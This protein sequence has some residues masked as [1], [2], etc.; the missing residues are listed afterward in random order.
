MMSEIY[1]NFMIFGLESTG[2][3]V[4]LDISEDTFRSNNGQNVLDP[5]QVLI[6]VKEGLRRIYIWK[7]VNSHVRKKFIASRIAAELQNDLVVNS[8]FHRCKII[9]V[10][11]GDEPN[12]FMRAFNF[13]S[14]K[15]PEILERDSIEF[16]QLHESSLKESAETKDKKVHG[17]Q[18]PPPTLNGSVKPTLIRKKKDYDIAPKPK[19]VIKPP[20]LDNKKLINKIVK[21][22]VPANFKRQNL[23]LGNFQI[24]G[25]AVKKA[26]VF[27]KEIEETEWEP[28]SSIPKGPI[29]LKDRTIRLYVDVNSGSI[30]GI[31]I[32]QKLDTS[33][34]EESIIKEKDEIDYNSWTVKKLKLHC[35][36]NNIS[37]PTSYRKAQIINLIRGGPLQEITEQP[38]DYNKW[39]VKKLKE[40]C[41]ENDLKVL[42]SYRKADLVKLVKEHKK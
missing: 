31:E 9:S 42:A 28:V 35:K 20:K 36:E 4:K 16:K 13:K 7:G 25:A 37:V 1:E 24:Y 30:E 5:N 23:I 2:E 38:L 11:Q 19:Q 27:G 22:K 32:L 14:V 33:K 17:W 40:Y 12:E 21:N 39:T 3:K 15:V 29:E 18:G 6:I 34:I 8:H 26:K 10:D 41:I